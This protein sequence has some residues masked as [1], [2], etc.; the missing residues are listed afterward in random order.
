MAGYVDNGNTI[1]CDTSDCD[2]ALQSL[3]SVLE[4]KGL[5]YK[6]EADGVREFEAIGLRFLWRQQEDLE[7]PEAD[8]EIVLC[9]Q[10]P[11]EAGTAQRTYNACCGWS[12]CT[13]RIA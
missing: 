7:R 12:P 13:F 2:A 6:V 11:S 1:A 3:C 9:S 8:V 5:V 4:R 10:T